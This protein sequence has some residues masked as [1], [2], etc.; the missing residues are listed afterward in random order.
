MKITLFKNAL[1]FFSLLLSV[2]LNA[3]HF[4]GGNLWYECL[5]GGC[6]YRIFQTFYF[7][8]ASASAANY[9]PAGLS[10]TNPPSSSPLSAMGQGCTATISSLTW[11][12]M[13]FEEVTPVCPSIQTACTTPGATIN[14]VV[15]VT[16]YSDYNACIYA[17]GCSEVTISWSSCCRNYAITS[18]ASGNGIY[19]STTIDLSLSSC[20]SSP[21]FENSAF[22]YICAG[23]TQTISQSAYDLDGDSLSY[24]LGPCY[25]SATQ[26]VTYNAGYSP[27]SPLGP[28]WLVNLDPVSGEMTFAPNPSG[29]IVVG[30]VCIYVNEWRNGVQIGQVSRDM[31]LYVVNC[32]TQ[33]ANDAPE[34]AIQAMSGGN[35]VHANRIEVSAG[36]QISF[37]MVFTDPDTG[38]SLSFHRNHIP[39]T[40][41]LTP[42]FGSSALTL[43]FDWTPSAADT[44]NHYVWADVFDDAC[45]INAHTSRYLDIVVKEASLNAIVTPTPCGVNA[46]AIDL[47]VLSGMPPFTFLWSNA[48]TTEDL[49]G[50]SGGVYSVAVTDSIGAVFN[51]TYYVNNLGGVVTNPVVS[52][53]TCNQNSGTID[54]GVSGGTP[55]YQYAWSNGATTPVLGNLSPGGY[56]VNITDSLGCFLH[57]V[58]IA[59]AP[60]F[61]KIG[62]ILFS[63][64]NGN[65][66]KDNGENV[67]PY[68]LIDINPGGILFSDVN[69][70][71]EVLVDTGTFAFNYLLPNNPYMSISCP[72]MASFNVHIPQLGIDSTDF[73]IPVAVDS[74]IDLK[75]SL[76]INGIAPGI[77]NQSSYI[78]YKNMSFDPGAP[79]QITYQH[80][81]LLFNPSFSLPPST[82]TPATQTAV[83]NFPTGVPYSPNYHIISILSQVD[84]TATIGDTAVGYVQILPINGDA[85]MTNNTDTAHRVVVASLDPNYKEVTPSGVTNQGYIP[86]NTP[87]LEYTV[88]FQ[89]TGTWYAEYVIIKDKLDA[90]LDF[91][92]LEYLAAS[93]NCTFAIDDND[94]LII[95]FA[96]IHLPDSG[97]DMAGSQGFVRFSFKPKPVLVPETT[98][99]NTAGIYFDFNAPVITN[100]VNSTFHLPATISLSSPVCEGNLITA[101]VQNGVPPFVWNGSV[102]DNTG[103]Y[104]FPAGQAGNYTITLSDAFAPVSMNFSVTD[105]PDNADFNYTST[106]N[107][108][109]FT[110]Q[111]SGYPDYFWD[112]GNGSTST[113]TFPTITYAQSGNYNIILTVSNE[114]GSFTDTMTVSVTTGLE[115]TAFTQSVKLYPNP[116]SQTALLTFDNP[117]K[118]EYTLIIRDVTGRLISS[119]IQS[120]HEFQIETGKLASGVYTWELRGGKVATG[121]FTVGE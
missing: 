17:Q 90:N 70:Y 62:G 71:Y 117:K 8:C 98:V 52:G 54:P 12:M 94:T 16:Y 86:Y 108:F 28:G 77:S 69:G 100:T 104:Y 87:K 43:H 97:T 82:Y 102:L 80:S 79:A 21:V 30:V 38:Q 51:A 105:V 58:V 83:W 14:G 85:D 47:T 57:T 25:Q 111:N 74:V 53:F 103:V 19:F 112:F 109:L 1:F 4:G 45:V 26:P 96:N 13:Y 63:D 68:G 6:E 61:S 20:N 88:H 15:A 101:T 110:P 118:S 81:P 73:N 34:V 31:L 106:G 22:A 29:P 23:Q 114:C 40:A 59:T 18:G 107:T 115:G 66:I 72:A 2:N 7:D 39:L 93:H 36:Q 44:G 95:T 64:G 50:L 48:A 67:I 27:A 37:D 5:P 35:M 119:Q 9:L 11:K 78:H 91:T 56:S 42:I 116:A 10:N 92:S 84:T 55:P 46:G 33:V 65:C 89:N 24:S 76:T 60:C 113:L 32:T 49:S 120:G 121:R 75:V 41:S 99:S 3:S